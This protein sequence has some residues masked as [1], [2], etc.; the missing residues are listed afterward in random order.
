VLIVGG[1]VAG[2]RLIGPPAAPAHYAFGRGPTIV[3]VHG[4]GSRIEHWLPVARRLAHAHRVVLVELPGH[5]ESE[6]PAPFTLDRVTEA[7]DRELA[8]E[9]GPVVLVGHSVGG[10]VAANLAIRDPQRVRA[11][12]L[13]ETV[14]RPSLDEAGRRELRAALDHDYAG[15]V[16]DVYRSFGR[17][18]A[19]GE[20]LWSEVAQL[21]RSMVR[22][23][24]DLAL[25]ADLS[26][27]TAALTMPV[28]AVFAERNWPRD[29]SWSAVA[30]DLGYVGTPHLEAVRFPDC[31][32]F[33]MLDCA[34]KLA[35]RIE[36]FADAPAPT[37]LAER[38]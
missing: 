9:A 19:Q 5:G 21:D 14:L 2:A 10:L 23:W 11:L 24:I 37:Q 28:L 6:M 16:H 8:S 36:R 1:A 29:S 12:V 15:V 4:L 20:A 31:G 33:V 7:L 13:V 25:D 30:G 34:D 27:K 38:R 22:S 35:A 17:D 26:G 32:H 3:M 18:S